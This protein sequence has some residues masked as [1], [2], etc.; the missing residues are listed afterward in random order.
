MKTE[1]ETPAKL[2]DFTP[3]MD[4][5]VKEYDVITAAVWGRVWRY[6]QGYYNACQA[7]NETI[8]KE[9][10]L[11]ERTVIRKIQQLEKDGYLIDHTPDLRNKP[12]T[13]S[14]TRKAR[15]EIIIQGVTESHP[16]MTQ[17]HPDYDTESHEETSKKQI[18]KEGASAVPV[19]VN[20]CQAC[21]KQV[22]RLIEATH[23]GVAYLA[24]SECD[25]RGTLP[26][27]M[28]PSKNGHDARVTAAILQGGQADSN[29]RDECQ[30]YLHFT[31]DWKTKTN[32]DLMQT[33]K[34]RT[35]TGQ[36]VKTFADW[37]WRNHWRGKQGQPPTSKDIQ[38]NWYAAF[39]SLETTPVTDD[40]SFY[41]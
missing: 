16:G 31:P 35:A 8:A 25:I 33:L 37:Y 28:R 38:E 1:R 19:L 34:L 41:V 17:S 40:G 23:K 3:L 9:L 30:R 22:D 12:H 15:I 5:L 29:I 21:G 4:S 36:T 14:T 27:N 2:K 6:E 26:P 24:C 10:G 13:Y 32:G 39:Q 7:S 20:K 11:S 18:K